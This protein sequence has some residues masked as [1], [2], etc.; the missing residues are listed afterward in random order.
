[1]EKGNFLFLNSQSKICA[2]ARSA[3]IRHKHMQN[4]LAML[5]SK[6]RMNCQWKRWIASEWLLWAQITHFSI[7]LRSSRILEN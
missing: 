4:G 3:T 7:I 2:A 1:M 6:Y 5:T